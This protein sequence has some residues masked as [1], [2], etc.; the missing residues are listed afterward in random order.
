MDDNAILDMYFARD[1]SAIAE[2]QEKYGK[3]CSSIAYNVL[4]SSEDAD[5]T[6]NDT[7]LVAWNAIP[8]QRPRFF[9]SFL[10]KI[11]RNL[12]LKKLR[13]RDVQKRG[14]ITA[15]ICLEELAEC[16]PSSSGVEEEIGTRELAAIIDSFLRAL[17]E[18]QRKIFLRRYWY[19]DTIEEISKNFG[20]GQSKVKM[21]LLR[22][23][24]KLLIELEKEGVNL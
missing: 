19:M 14:G 11:T 16:I 24:E 20:F 21:M 7:Y 8:P 6:V 4:G 12:A 15:H 13:S 18:M 3:Y 22:T 17:P 9:S 2:T 5:E 1:E 10:G 23:R